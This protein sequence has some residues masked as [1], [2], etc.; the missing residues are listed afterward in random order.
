MECQQCSA[1]MYA[2]SG[3]GG[4]SKCSAGRF[5]A[6]EAGSCTGCPPGKFS[7][8]PG[9]WS[10]SDG[11]VRCLY[12]R[13]HNSSWCIGNS[14]GSA[15]E[16]RACIFCHGYIIDC[17]LTW[18]VTVAGLLATIGGSVVFLNIGFE[19][20]DGTGT[21]IGDRVLIPA[22]FF[23]ILN[24]TLFAFATENGN[25]FKWIHVFYLAALFCRVT[26]TLL[27]AVCSACHWKNT[28]ESQNQNL[29]INPGRVEQA[30]VSF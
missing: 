12:P 30:T 9:F 27:L 6:I 10:L 19:I 25:S 2:S 20:T 24:V 5:S 26:F 28:R 16:S 23:I 14:Y 15:N 8:E 22:A 7:E 18:V 21:L 1:G 17:D 4:C 11:P 3:A 13:W 29:M